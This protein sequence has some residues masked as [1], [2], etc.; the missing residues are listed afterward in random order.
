MKFC[1]I[2]GKKDIK[3]EFCTE[4]Y[5]EKINSILEFKEINIKICPVCMSYQFQSRQVSFDDLNVVVKKIT[6]QNIQKNLQAEITPM[7]PE[8]E[9]RPGKRYSFEI[10]VTLSPEERFFIPGNIEMDRCSKCDRQGS[11]YF[12]GILQIRNPNKEVIE[13][14]R[15]EVAKNNSKGVFITKEKR[16]GSG[17]DFWF[18]SQRYMQNLGHLL[19]KTFGGILKINPRIYTRNRQTSK[20]VYR[21]S[22]YFELLGYNTGDIVKVGDKLIKVTSTGKQV[23][24]LNLITGKRTSFSSKDKAEVI[25]KRKADVINV[26]PEIEIMDPETYQPLKVENK[27]KL[28][29]GD[30]VNIITYDGKVYMV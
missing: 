4:C 29:L 1:P 9:Y 7:L 15:K 23:A 6:K 20:D 27:K 24:G 5:A 25:P 12:E 3:G 8:I 14:I 30:K 16:E 10:E 22:V 17:F 28:K 21:M 26:Y 2:C 19:Y 18:S 11:Q 13:F